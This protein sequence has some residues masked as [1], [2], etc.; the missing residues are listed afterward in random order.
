[1]T[2]IVLVSAFGLGILTA[3]SPCPLAANIVAT[4]FI[5][6][7]AGQMNH[8][9]ISGFMYA[10]G[11]IIVYVGLGAAI[12]AGFLGSSDVSLF[13]QKYMNEA[14]GPLLIFLGLIL[15]EWIGT[16]VSLSLGTA[17]LQEKGAGA[18]VVWSLPM[19]ALFALSFC[20]VSAGLFFGALLPM[21]LKQQSSFTLPVLYG[22]GTA[23]PVVIF[24]FLLAFGSAY[25]GSIFNRLTDIEAWIR[26]I[27]G[28]AFILT[29]IYYC[30]T[31]IYGLFL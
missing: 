25:V 11:R 19:G 2:W 22:L 13:L 30:V 31:H 1:M 29:G 5:G 9:L 3:I 12:T 26:R 14:L 7:K 6:R 24:A 28:T 17:R 20:P 23:L 4:S 27:A 10:L 16:G 8:V 15:L 21:T 18:G